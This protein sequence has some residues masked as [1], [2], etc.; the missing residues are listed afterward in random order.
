MDSRITL[1]NNEIK[2][3]IKVIISL[4]TREILEELLKE[5]SV[6]QMYSH[7]RVLRPLGLTA[8]ALATFL[9]PPHLLTIFE[10]RKYYKKPLNLMMFIQKIIYLK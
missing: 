9:I 8:A 7:K 5:D 4:E 10:K 3:I 2:V 6:G 1:T